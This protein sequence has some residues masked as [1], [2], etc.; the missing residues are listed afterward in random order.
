MVYLL[1]IRGVA[2]QSYIEL[3]GQSRLV[4]EMTS[5]GW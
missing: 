2:L 1:E 3:S 5:E 4:V